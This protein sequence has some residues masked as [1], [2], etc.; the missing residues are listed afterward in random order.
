MSFT[1]TIKPTSITVYPGRESIDYLGPLLDLL[2]Y[3]DEYVEET[4]TLGYIYDEDTDLLYLHKGVDINYLKKLLID[5]TFK[6]QKPD[7]AKE[8][9]FEY[10]EIIPPRDDEQVDVINFITGS[11]HHANNITANQIFLVLRTGAG[12]S[13]C[14][15]TGACKYHKRTL[16]IM[17]RDNLRNQWIKTLLDMIGMDKNRIHEIKTTD[18][19]VAI[20]HNEINML[21]DYDIYLM[22]HATFRAGLKR[23]HSFEEA[24]NITK[25]LGIGLKIIDEAHLEFRD[26]L[27]MDFVFNV[28]R[29]LYLTATAGRS[30]K[31]ENSI[32][33]HVFSHAVFYK[34]SSLLTTNM[35]K[36]WVEYTIVELD[37]HVKPNIYR[38]RVN[39]GRGMNPASYGKWVI[40]NDKKQIHFKVCTELIRQMF[41]ND[42]NSKI[43]V[44]MPLIE[45]CS[46]FEYF[47][48]KTLNYDSSFEYSLELGTIN[49]SNTKS[50]N[51]R[52]KKCDV[53]ITTIAS[54]GTGTDLPGMTGIINCSPFVSKITASQVFG[55]LRYCGKTCYFYDVYDKSVQM[56]VFWLKS[57]S[58]VMK[59][60]ALNV[61]SIKW[62]D[63][64]E[65]E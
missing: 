8:M 29:N 60:L 57:R 4:K 14:S 39:G 62:N 34:P 18:E 55:R 54:C 25:N 41:E 1:V 22:T 3:E 47:L 40:K 38:Y 33:K 13:F 20:A 10:E 53:I 12:K 24:S 9:D 26:T 35:P 31:E 43:L 45:L 36:K 17:H 64:D 37:T 56:D 21:Y 7:Q 49:S 15:C 51:E 32:F 61:R 42:K 50:E 2:T 28:Q 5:V 59:S 52:N 46:E 30:S 48:N 6:T 58:K 23:L 65:G 27:L 19:I 16:I 44:F 11:Q 63:D